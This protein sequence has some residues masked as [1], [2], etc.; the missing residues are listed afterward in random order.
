M[1]QL[2]DILNDKIIVLGSKAALG[3]Q[4]G[5]TGEAILQYINGRMPSF[6]IAIRW[7]EVFHEN[8]IDLI[9]DQEKP[10]VV[11]EPEPKYSDLRHDLIDCQQKLIACYEEK[12]RLQQALDESTNNKPS[13]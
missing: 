8:L 2:S 7:K 12:Q 4:L 9:F 10:T 6:Q 3:R 1:R 11:S 13:P 5:V